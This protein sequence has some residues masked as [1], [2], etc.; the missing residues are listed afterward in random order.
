[1]DYHGITHPCPGWLLPLWRRVFCRRNIHAF[2]EVGCTEG[3][4][5]SCDACDLVVFIKSV[6]T[7]YQE[8]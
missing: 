5:L 2:D 7:T 1:M 4:Y 6:D 3:G 8:L